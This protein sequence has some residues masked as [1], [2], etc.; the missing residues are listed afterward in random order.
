MGRPVRKS[1]NDLLI[2]RARQM[3]MAHLRLRTQLL[4]ATLL[5]ILT[6]LGAVLLIVRH[7]MRSEIATGARRT[8]NASLQ[9]LRTSKR[10]RP[11]TLPNSGLARRF[12]HAEGHNGH[13]ECGNNSRCIGTLVEACRQPGFCSCE[14]GRT[15]FRVSCIQARMGRK[16]RAGGPLKDS[17]EQ[18]NESA[19]WYGH[20]RLY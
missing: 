1:G 7:G 4:V 16:H 14:S 17:L 9:L 10:A 15:V 12:A 5:I 18:G 11:A 2:L 3:H 20:G 19:W 13:A 8:T 6:L